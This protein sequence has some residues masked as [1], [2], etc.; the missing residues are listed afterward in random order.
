MSEIFSIPILP[1][2]ENAHSLIFNSKTEKDSYVKGE[3]KFC[4]DERGNYYSCHHNMATEAK[5][6]LEVARVKFAK[7]NGFEPSKYKPRVWERKE[8]EDEMA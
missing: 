8:H 5:K 4:F 6:E 1:D 2:G 7:S 3:F